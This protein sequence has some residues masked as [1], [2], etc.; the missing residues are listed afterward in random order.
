MADVIIHL[1]GD[2]NRVYETIQA[3]K[4]NP[5]A[6]IIVSS[7]GNPV[8]V[9]QQLQAAG[10]SRNRYVF[11]F[12]AWDTVT[13]FTETKRWVM[14]QRPQK[15]FV[16]T[17]EFHMVRAEVIANYV[18]WKEGVTVVA[19][20]VAN[21]APRSES[22][23]LV[24]SDA[25]RA[26]LWRLTGILIADGKVKADRMPGISREKASAQANNVPIA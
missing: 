7:E 21:R 26:L 19:C 12:N 24:L 11:D 18:F 3:A 2:P 10:I 6:L 22:W 5:S 14:R 9:D 4:N 13:N 8:W 17:N 1:G 23:Q 20:P 15:L 25:A 16:V